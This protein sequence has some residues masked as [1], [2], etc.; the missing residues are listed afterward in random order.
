MSGRCIMCG[1]ELGYDG[2]H[3]ERCVEEEPNLETIKVKVTLSTP[4]DIDRKSVV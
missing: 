2:T 3:C 1:R 4:K